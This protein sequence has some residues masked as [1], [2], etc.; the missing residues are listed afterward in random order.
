MVT[1]AT[2][3]SPDVFISYNA[4]DIELAEALYQRLVDSG[5][6]NIWFDRARLRTG[7]DWY[8]EIKAGCERS[9]VILPVLT[10]RWK[11]S[12]WTKFET[13][14][15]ERVIPLVFEGQFRVVHP[16]GKPDWEASVATPPLTRFQ[17]YSMDAASE[18]DGAWKRLIETL[19]EQIALPPPEKQ[20]RCFEIP[21]DPNPYFV[22]REAEMLSIHETLHQNPTAALTQGKV[23]AI[24][25][26]GGVGKTT[27]AREYIERFW[28]CYPQIFWIDCRLGVEAG[29]AHVLELL[30]PERA[31][32]LRPNER[33]SAALRELSGEQARLLVLDNAEDETSIKDWIPRG[34][35]SRTIITSRYANWSPGVVK[36]EMWVLEPE[37]ARAFL[38]E[39][40]GRS[41]TG[42]ELDA[43]DALAKSLGYL[44]LA[45]EQAGAY[46]A[47]NAHYT[48]RSYLELYREAEADLLSEGALGST[49]YPDPVATTWHLTV[50]KLSAPARAVLRI[51]SF[52]ADAPIPL[53]MLV[54]GVDAIREIANQFPSARSGSET[55]SER[56]FVDRLGNELH[57]YSMARQSE[58][59]LLFHNLVQT[60]ET[61]NIPR[62]QREAASRGAWRIFW[63]FAP[64]PAFEYANWDQWRILHP[65]A[66]R[67]VQDSSA[68]PVEVAWGQTELAIFLRS[69][70][71]D[72]AKAEPLCRRALAG[73]ERV[74]GPE[75]PHTLT[76]VND[77]AAL[78]DSKGAYEEAEPLYRRCLEAAEKAGRADSAQFAIHLN[79]HALLL[80][81]LS[82][83]DDAA[84]LLARAISIEDRSIA[85]DHPKRAHRRNN[86][87]IVHLLAG[88][89]DK[90][91]TAN[92][93]A[94]RLKGLSNGGHDLTS[95]RILWVRFALT[96]LQR[97]NAS[98]SLGQLRTVLLRPNL[99]CLGGIDLRWDVADV[100]STLR[101]RLAHDEVELLSALVDVLNDRSPL[102]EL[103]RFAQWARQPGVPLEMPW[104]EPL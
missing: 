11:R 18:G 79:N 41:A 36:L 47:R 38:I 9:R 72:Y 64:T 30:E 50:A 80:R 44:P 51:C 20:T 48:F 59:G 63:N 68:E 87:A 23:H 54:A 84:S 25:A 91:V 17:A 5:V 71:V 29:F 103:N 14:A 28:R 32:L 60:V 19:R 52:Y 77:L 3:S 13:Y 98:I 101:E 74:L 55:A 94:W 58:N 45:L 70:L 10:P 27:L 37:P 100:V 57:A 46:L 1:V 61:L 40:T 33:A 85:A 66:S 67:L 81:K 83:Y 26:M 6:E 102:N 31:R 92:V 43:C 21:Y 39:R 42:D 34:G 69:A 7:F 76:S 53:A 12:A 90:A 2:P 86:L 78:L 56:V 4:E 89:L 95:A 97:V 82:R 35:G 104:S 15:H 16:D 88:S 24:A 73:Y 75:H 62:D 93:E 22:G 96:L 99:P 65:H 8:A 49:H